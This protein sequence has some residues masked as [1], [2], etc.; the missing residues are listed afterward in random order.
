MML[1]GGIMAF[2]ELNIEA[3]PDPT[4]PM[5]VTD[6]AKPGSLGR[7]DRALHHHPHRDADLPPAQPNLDPHDFAYGLSD[8]KLQFRST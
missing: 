2:R 5:V 6:H 8:V 7:G 3:Y 1:A 4:P